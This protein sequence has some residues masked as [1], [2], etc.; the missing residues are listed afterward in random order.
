VYEA[1]ASHLKGLT[2]DECVPIIASTLKDRM[3]WIWSEEIDEAYERASA[4]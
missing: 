2:Y 3:S 1:E 4:S